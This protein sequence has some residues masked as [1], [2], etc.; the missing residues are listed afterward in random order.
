MELNNLKGIGPKTQKQLEKIGIK[1]VEDFVTYYPYRYQLIKRSNPWKLKQNDLIIMDGIVTTNASVS[2]F[3][4]KQN[5]MVFQ[6]ESSDNYYQVII[7]NRGYLKKKLLIGT[8]ITVIG[9]FD[10]KNNRIIASELRFGCI[11]NEKIER[12]YHLTGGIRKQILTNYIDEALTLPYEV[13]DLIPDEINKKYNFILKELAIKEIHHPTNTRLL[14]EARKKLIYEELFCYMMKV[15]YLKLYRT[16]KKGTKHEFDLSRITKLINH[17]PFSLTIDQ[18]VCIN[19][20]LLDM[21]TDYQM[22]RLLQGDVGSGKTIVAMIA[23]YANYL[24]GY[25]GA[26]MAPTEI[27]ACQHYDDMVKLFPD[28]KIALFTGKLK[29]KERKELLERLRNSDI[30]IIIGTHSLISD[31]VCYANLG[32][33]ITDEQHRFGVE[34]RTR[35][36]KKGTSPDIL[37]MSAT[38]IPRTYALT[39]YGD[40]DVSNIKTMPLGRKPVITILKKEHEIKDVLYSMLEQLKLGHQIY[41]VA[42]LIEDD[43]SSKNDIEKLT[44]N[45][46][47]AFGEYFNIGSLHGKMK[48][49]EKDKVMDDFK[50]NVIQIL[51]STTVVE[52]GVNV[53]NATM[54]VIFNAEQFGLATIHQLRGRVGRSNIQSYCILISDSDKERLNILTETTDG[55]KISEEDFKLRGSGDLFGQKQSGDMVFKIADLKRDYKTLLLAKMDSEKYLKENP[56]SQLVKKIVERNNYV[57]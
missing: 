10:K 49:N 20:V 27:L 12:V 1:K 39:L 34:Q 35:L 37:S 21:Q 57:S 14:K 19:E 7:F 55:F 50:N 53:S 38:P 36:S 51:I 18:Q 43:E 31:D 25:Q 28:L 26:M 11:E 30:D 17:L 15:N 9:K 41:V 16:K 52:V 48:Q 4:K 40:M 13:I 29:V 56:N 33:I 23:L 3:G 22:N 45:M 44:A 8:A 42:P 6:L 24:S 32:L 54:M 46:K 5:R 2:F 47:K